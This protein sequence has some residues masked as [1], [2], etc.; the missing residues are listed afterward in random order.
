MSAM[1]KSRHLRPRRPPIESNTTRPLTS[2]S[3]VTSASRDASVISG[4]FAL[5]EVCPLYPQ[6]R[7]FAEQTSMSAKGQKRTSARD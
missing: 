5:R 2:G 4:H 7:T 6:E 3:V 1:A